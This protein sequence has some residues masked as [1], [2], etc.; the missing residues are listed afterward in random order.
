M[1][2]GFKEHLG[3]SDQKK[4]TSWNHR[5]HTVSLRLVPTHTEKTKP[6]QLAL[7]NSQNASIAV[8]LFYH[9]NGSSTQWPRKHC[10]TGTNSLAVKSAIKPCSAQQISMPQSLKTCRRGADT[11]IAFSS[12]N[13]MTAAFTLAPASLKE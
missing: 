2:S 5:T 6:W 11:V 9:E 8:F 3:T 12:F 13:F 7:H 1:S 10:G 4:L